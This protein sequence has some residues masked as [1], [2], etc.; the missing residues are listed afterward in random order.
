[1]LFPQQT[2]LSY[3]VGHGVVYNWKVSISLVFETDNFHWQ[4]Y[5]H[6]DIQTIYNPFNCGLLL[7]LYT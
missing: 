7:G 4:K 2:E 5:K 1:M 3:K 6:Q